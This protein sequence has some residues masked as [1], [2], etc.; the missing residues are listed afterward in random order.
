M[1]P[2]LNI[3]LNDVNPYCF[4]YIINEMFIAH[5]AKKNATNEISFLILLIKP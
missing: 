4:I 1:S 5:N 2:L 3:L